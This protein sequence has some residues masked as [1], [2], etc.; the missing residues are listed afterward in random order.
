MFYTLIKHE[1]LTIQNARRS[2]L[3]YNSG[4]TL[5]KQ[6]REMTKSYIAWKS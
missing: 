5:L 2:Y 3:Y 4:G 1:C 6:Q